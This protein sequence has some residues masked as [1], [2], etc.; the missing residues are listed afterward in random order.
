M[1]ARATPELSSGT[2]GGSGSA[3]LTVVCMTAGPGGRVSSLLGLLRD[4]ADEILVAV[5]DRADT[6]VVSALATV[7]DRLVL[8]PYAPP[9]DAPLPWLQAE[10]R[11]E[12]V[13]HLDD[14]EIPSEALLER[15]P[16]MLA[17]EEV[18]HWWLPRRW[19]FGTAERYLDEHPWRPDY[20]LRLVRNDPRL[21]RFSSEFHRPIVALGPGRFAD[22]VLWHADCLLRPYEARIAK[23]RAYERL[24]PGMRIAGRAYNYA[25]YVPELAPGARTAAVPDADRRLLDALLAAADPHAPDTNGVRTERVTREELDA[26]WPGRGLSE[27]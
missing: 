14:D 26:R 5:D 15:L 24:R 19:L 27:R 7:A 23:A 25:V 6:A 8:Y 20:Q 21:V 2:G 10:A 4:V 22:G 12:W 11:G 17:D 16:A 3:S 13:L 9:V 1:S 18:T